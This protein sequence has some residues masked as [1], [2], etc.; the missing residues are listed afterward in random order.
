MTLSLID[1]CRLEIEYDGRFT[2][3][4]PTG[5]AQDTT[6]Y[7]DTPVERLKTHNWAQWCDLAALSTRFCRLCGLPMD[8]VEDTHPDERC[9]IYIAMEVALSQD[10]YWR[11]L[12]KVDYGPEDR[13]RMGLE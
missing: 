8:P 5:D 12:P 4:K 10:D 3:Q 2:A 1:D 6:P 9:P 7:G 13:N 11:N